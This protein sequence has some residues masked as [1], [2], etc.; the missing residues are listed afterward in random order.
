MAQEIEIEFKNLLTEEEYQQL[1]NHFYS[2]NSTEMIQKNHYFETADF[3]IK[4]HH[5]A[6]RIREKENTY[7]LTLKQPNPHGP[8]LL[9]THADLTSSEAKLSLEGNFVEK[10][11]IEKALNNMGISHTDLKYGGMLQTYRIESNYKDTMIVLD[12]SE[13]NGHT[14]YELELE[15]H[16]EAYGLKIFQEILSN[17]NIPKRKTAN[18]IERFYKTL[19]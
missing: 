3:Q 19:K 9:E 11:E 1:V 18:K 12:K 4:K 13:Y 16:D 6:L 2:S 15:A 8:G 14:D 7:Q 5:A 17:H 10:E